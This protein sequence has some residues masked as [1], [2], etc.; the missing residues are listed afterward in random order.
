MSQ[1]EQVIEF[2]EKWG[3]IDSHK[4]FQ[5]F[6][7]TRLAAVIHELKGT[8][9][10]MKAV[11]DGTVK[12]GFARYEADPEERFKAVKKQLS[13]SCSKGIQA[14]SCPRDVVAALTEALRNALTWAREVGDG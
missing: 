6:G 12:S 14:A 5:L 11:Y 8:E 4:A 1:K 9:H 7:I 10:A 2:V 13:E 3:S